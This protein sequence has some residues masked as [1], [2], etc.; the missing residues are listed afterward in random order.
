MANIEKSALRKRLLE[1]RIQL[2]PAVRQIAE[3]QLISNVLSDESWK[4]AMHIASYAAMKGEADL[5]PLHQLA[6]QQGKH[7]FLPTLK[8]DSLQF[9]P[10]SSDSVLKQNQY[11]IVEPIVPAETLYSAA[12]LDLLLIPLVGFD[13]HGHRLGMGKGYFDNTLAP[14]M[15]LPHRPILMGVAFS[16]QQV[17]E[18]SVD[19]WDIPLDAIATEQGIVRI[20]KIY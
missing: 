7:L 9:A 5:T 4:Q 13:L 6:W 19:P 8:I 18:I 14:L 1:Q 2:S 17:D 20:K 12:Q 11:H 16:F 3:E 15:N 10:Y